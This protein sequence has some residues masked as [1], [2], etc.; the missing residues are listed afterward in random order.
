MTWQPS[1]IV[2]PP[3][4]NVEEIELDQTCATVV[5]GYVNELDHI[6]KRPCPSLWLNLGTG[7]PVDGLFWWDEKNTVL[8]VSNGRV[9][10]ITDSAGTITELT[11][12]TDLLAS[13][14]CTFAYTA[15]K[16]VIANG[17]KMVTTDL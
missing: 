11:G 9:W 6:Y 16:A 8:A 7:L 10:K 2:G 4:E 12:S 5:D 15:T 1:P 13:A 17:G 14:Q 3:N